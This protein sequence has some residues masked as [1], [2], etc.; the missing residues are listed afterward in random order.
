MKKVAIFLVSWLFFVNCGGGSSGNSIDYTKDLVNNKTFYEV[1]C[2]DSNKSY[3]TAYFRDD[4]FIITEYED[5][6]FSIKKDSKIYPI[7]QYFEDGFFITN[8]DNT[9]ECSISSIDEIFIT[10][11]CVNTSLEADE[12]DSIDFVGYKDKNK[13][14]E[15]VVCN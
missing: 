9:Y 14:L 13:A 4:Y 10:I 15:S 6:N 1:L 5:S 3:T 7:T 11:N 12:M 2:T 8:N